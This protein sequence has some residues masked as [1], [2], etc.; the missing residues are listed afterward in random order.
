[1]S[2]HQP[3][4]DFPVRVASESFKDNNDGNEELLLFVENT[5]VNVSISNIVKS[6]SFSIKVFADTPH[7]NC[8]LCVP[9]TPVSI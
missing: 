9:W 6:E 8:E 3:G 1:M 4:V 5:Q 2:F 7:L